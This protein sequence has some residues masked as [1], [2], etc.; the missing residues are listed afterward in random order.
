MK[1]IVPNWLI[2]LSWFL[3]GICATGAFWYFLSKNDITH[4]WWSLAGTI[5]FA[6]LAIYHQRLNDSNS[7]HLVHRT[8]LA[9][10]IEESKCLRGRLKEIPLPIKDFNDWDETVLAYLQDNLDAS[11]VVRFRD[12]TGMV[13]Y[14]EGTESSNLKIEI[15][16]R[17][18][19]LNEFLS[20]LT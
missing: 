12:F 20:E 3:A 11:Y 6:V 5:F 13:F 2:Q 18:R 4:T 19:R 17:T 9:I 14:G 8:K 10:F 7:C 15:A 1:K 16:G